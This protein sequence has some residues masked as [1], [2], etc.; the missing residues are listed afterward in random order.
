MHISD[1][2]RETFERDGA[3]CLRGVYDRSAVESL[4]DAWDR[5]V[6]DPHASGLVPP[7]E[8][9]RPVGDRATVISRP[10]YAVDAFRTFI[11]ESPVPALM[12]ELMNQREVGFYWDTIFA[13]DPGSTWETAWHTDA[14]AIAVRGNDMINVWTPLTPVTRD[15]SLEVV[16]GTHRNDVLYWPKSPNGARLER[17]RDRDF[18]PDFGAHRGED[19]YRFITWDMEPG[20]VVF[21]HLK[22]AHYNRGNPTEHRRV[23]LATWWYGD[24]I[25]WDPRPECETGHPEAPFADMPRGRHPDHP[26]FPVLWRASGA[27]RS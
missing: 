1:A 14:G 27:T 23:A 8:E 22:T 7:E 18:C 6:A 15:N 21:M 13:K 24:D 10:S 2:D 5:I 25:V 3:V 17:P 20:D 12:G 9:F 26:L 11:H 16:A 19:G 4:L